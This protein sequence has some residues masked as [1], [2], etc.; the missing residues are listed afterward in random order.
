MPGEC[1]LCA[2]DSFWCVK[3]QAVLTQ[4]LQM[5]LTLLFHW[6]GVGQFSMQLEGQYWLQLH[7]LEADNR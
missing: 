5:S 2:T 4:E 1:Y 7:N 3:L 6:A